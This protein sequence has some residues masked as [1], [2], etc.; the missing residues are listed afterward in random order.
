M[1][2]QLIL[3]SVL[4]AFTGLVSAQVT[5]GGT[6]GVTADIQGSILVTFISD[7]SGLAVTGTGSSSGSL[8]FSN[9]Q[10]YGGTPATG[11]TKTLTS[12]T[13]YT[14]ST[15][16]DIQVDV[17]NTASSSYLLKAWLTTADTHHTWTF[18]S[19]DLTSSSQTVDATGTYGQPNAYTFVL[20]VPASSNGAANT[21][22]NTVNFTATA[23]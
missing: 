11:V 5:G 23:N 10:M 13:S 6:L 22:S 17:A 3:I 12:N 18:N 9:E 2:R 4:S 16:V 8:P 14:L 1:K 7:G 15:P 19:V 21:I 20:T